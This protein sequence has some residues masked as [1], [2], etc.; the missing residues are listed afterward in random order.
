LTIIGINIPLISI[1]FSFSQL[2]TKIEKV[3]KS[4][5]KEVSKDY[6]DLIKNAKSQEEVDG[7][8]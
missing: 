7:L 6:I 8:V 1:F 3:V 4:I 5:E 2:Q